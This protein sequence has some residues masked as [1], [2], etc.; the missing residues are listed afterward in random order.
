[1]DGKILLIGGGLGL[2]ALYLFRKKNEDENNAKN[3]DKETEDL[4]NKETQ[5]ALLLKSLL[6]PEKVAVIGWTTNNL[7]SRADYPK[8]AE[9][10]NTL[11][12]VTKWAAVQNSFLKL[13]NKEYTLLN[14]LQNALPTDIYKKAVEIAAAK[15]IQTVKDVTAILKDSTAPTGMV[16][17]QFQ[18]NTLIGALQK[19]S[20]GDVYFINGYKS[21]G[22]ILKDLIE[23]SGYV[24]KNSVKEI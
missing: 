19:Y 24:A 2:L 14:A 22:N 21:D 4:T 16:T 3:A 5:Q 9:I 8:V 18:K 20:G 15:K 23:M 12:S 7:K 1:M 10:L 11:L 17:L 6:N 13:C